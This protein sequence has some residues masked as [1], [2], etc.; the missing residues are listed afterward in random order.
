[1][2]FNMTFEEFVKCKLGS[3]NLDRLKLLV[4]ANKDIA[5]VCQKA[6][7][8]TSW[9]DYRLLTYVKSVMWIAHTWDAQ[10]RA[11]YARYLDLEESKSIETMGQYALSPGNFR[12][13]MILKRHLDQIGCSYDWFL[14]WA[15]RRFEMVHKRSMPEPDAMVTE[16]ILLD[17]ED[18]WIAICGA[19]LQRARHPKIKTVTTLTKDSEPYVE[20]LKRF[21]TTRQS[22]YITLCGLIYGQSPVISEALA[23]DLFGN[24]TVAQAKS[25]SCR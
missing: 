12:K 15:F 14:N 13:F 21:V 1:M 9:A 11:S 20:H 22:S 10:Y 25:L 4:K 24:S 2:I 5:A 6:H 23:I 19:T 16:T 17:A 18:A 8:E 7:K 3:Q